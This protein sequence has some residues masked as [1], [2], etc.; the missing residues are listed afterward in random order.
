MN[1]NSE[2]NLEF[3]LGDFGLS[4]T[5]KGKDYEH[6]TLCGTPNY[7]CP[8]ILIGHVMRRL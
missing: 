3:K 2:N 8:T 1:E 4:C 6:W 5:Y 7:I